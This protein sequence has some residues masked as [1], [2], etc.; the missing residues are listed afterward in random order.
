LYGDKNVNVEYTQNL[1]ALTPSAKQNLCETVYTNI[2]SEVF[3]WD[4]NLSFPKLTAGEA[5]SNLEMREGLNRNLG[6]TVRKQNI[7]YVYV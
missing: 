6:G 4:G 7:Q 5:F 2:L 1:L 3:L